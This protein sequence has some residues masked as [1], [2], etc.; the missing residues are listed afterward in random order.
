MVNNVQLPLATSRLLPEQMKKDT[1]NLVL[2]NQKLSK[3]GEKFKI[4]S[5][6][7]EK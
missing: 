6:E 2:L 4:T 1:P 5:Y 7:K 3:I